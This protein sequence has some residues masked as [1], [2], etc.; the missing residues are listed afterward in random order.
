MP[1][2]PDARRLSQKGVNARKKQVT[3]RRATT[4]PRKKY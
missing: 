3:K 2:R 4:K 1:T